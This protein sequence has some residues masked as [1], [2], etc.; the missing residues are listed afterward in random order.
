ML[1]RR[2]FALLLALA[3]ALAIVASAT[4]AEADVRCAPIEGGS[5]ALAAIDPGRRLD[6]IQRRLNADA[7][8]VRIWAWSWASIYTGLVVVNG[9]RLAL[10]RSRADMIDNGTATGASMLGLA[11]LAIMPPAV[12]RDQPRLARIVA[13]SGELD[14]D[15]CALVAAAERILLRDA[16]SEAFSVGP[17]PHA[18]NF[19]FNMGLG[20]LLAVG[21]GRLET[22]MIVALTGIT[23]G[24]IQMLSVR[25]RVRE[26]L[27]RYRSG[28]IDIA[29]E[30]TGDG[31]PRS[32]GWTVVPILSR[33][34][35][36]VQ[37]GLTF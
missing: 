25:T 4:H 12:L 36:G 11:V 10:S 22:G 9:T 3:L 7:R 6:F 2:S 17:L 15:R 31:A 20:L 32:I 29:G 24:E 14:S 33:E 27:A 19:V 37:F 23:V 28:A 8:R 16:A 26:T 30:R 21:F 13:R 34:R 5:S 18:G 1:L 35:Y